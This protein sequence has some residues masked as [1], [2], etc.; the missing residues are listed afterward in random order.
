V[1]VDGQANGD[2]CPSCGARR[3]AGSKQC[4]IC[5]DRARLRYTVSTMALETLAVMSI[6]VLAAAALLWLRQS[7]HGLATDQERVAEVE[8]VSEL[9]TPLPT[10]TAAPS[11][12][13][14]RVLNTVP[15]PV[16]PLPESVAHE[17]RS[18]DTLFG[19]AQQYSVTA[20]EII[21][22]SDLERPDALWIGQVL[23][24]PLRV[25]LPS[26]GDAEAVAAAGDTEEEG[27]ADATDEAGD[28]TATDADGG[29][30]SANEDDEGAAAGEPG[31]G[32]E[33][34]EDVEAVA[35]PTGQPIVVGE[36]QIHVVGR[37]ESIGVISALYD[38]SIEEL[39][40]L[41]PER[42]V[43]A[44]DTLYVGD[45][46]VV[47]QG[48][49]VTT[50]P[51]PSAAAPTRAPGFEEASGTAGEMSAVPFE[52][53]G[54][55]RYPA[56]A[57]LAPG[58]SITVTAESVLL[59]W[60]SAGVLPSGLFYVVSIRDADAAAAQLANSETGAISAAGP[61]SGTSAGAVI[62]DDRLGDTGARVIWVKDATAVRVPGELRPALGASSAIEWSVTVRRRSGSGLL[63][64]GEEGVLLSAAP[65]WQRFVWAPSAALDDT[66][67]SGVAAP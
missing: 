52:P 12:T 25:Q 62:G 31:E 39:L 3:P 45:E 26:E 37:G 58:A 33:A 35:Q 48:E 15:P 46:L 8:V 28:E 43:S 66:A 14:T 55:G 5:G 67:D 36:P 11:P 21:A 17:V 29:A 30:S 41:N 60:A 34:P 1:T 54:E 61:V 56:P 18:G 24:I 2:R 7:G 10:F 27:A 42:L 47:R 16:T 4:P 9:P 13:A 63:D 65:A 22:A 44:N 51:E 50:T 40:A 38:V 6:V 53:A 49:I 19:I 57:A 20:D 32:A 59:R 64:R 23:T